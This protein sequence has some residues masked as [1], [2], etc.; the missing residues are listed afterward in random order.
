MG[1]RA[2]KISIAA[3]L[4]AAG[5]LAT[6]LWWYSHGGFVSLCLTNNDLSAKE[7]EP[8]EQV[9][10]RL[11]QDIVLGIMDT[12]YSQQT[13]EAKRATTVAQLAALHRTY[14]DP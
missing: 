8:Y 1:P 2:K 7:R 11:A 9:G 12:V 6:E 10:L 3:F 14:D 13:A 4:I 5:A